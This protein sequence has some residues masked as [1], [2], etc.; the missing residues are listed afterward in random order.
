MSKSAKPKRIAMQR[1]Y[2]TLRRQKLKIHWEEVLPVM[3]RKEC[4]G[5]W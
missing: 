2:L 3:P 5:C 1:Q 4:A